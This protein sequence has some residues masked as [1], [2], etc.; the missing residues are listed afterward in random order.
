MIN[1]FFKNTGPHNINYLLKTINLKN[2][3]LSDDKITDIKDLNSSEKN[4]I[5][6]LHSKKYTDLAKNLYYE[7]QYF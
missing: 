5:T 3:N 1:S 7:D 6:F 2:D 4:E